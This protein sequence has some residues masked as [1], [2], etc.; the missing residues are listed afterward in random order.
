MWLGYMFGEYMIFGWRYRFYPLNTR[1]MT[2]AQSG[3]LLYRPDDAAWFRSKHGP[4]RWW[5]IRNRGYTPPDW[6]LRLWND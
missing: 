6:F 5:P 1:H 3:K 2:S 4:S